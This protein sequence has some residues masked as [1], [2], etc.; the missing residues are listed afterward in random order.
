MKYTILILIFL[1]PAFLSGC[2]DD[3]PPGGHTYPHFQSADETLLLKS[4]ATPFEVKVLHGDWH[5]G[6]IE[7]DGRIL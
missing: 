1:L 5:L 4:D 6:R 7:V 3:T 2:K